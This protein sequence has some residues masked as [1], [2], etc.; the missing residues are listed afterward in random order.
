MSWNKFKLFQPKMFVTV[1]FFVFC[2]QLYNCLFVSLQCLWLISEAT[3]EIANQFFHLPTLAP[4]LGIKPPPPTL[5]TILL[6][7]TSLS[8][9]AAAATSCISPGPASYP[10]C[11]EEHDSA[12]FTLKQPWFYK[13][14]YLLCEFPIKIKLAPGTALSGTIRT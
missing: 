4:D 11:L 13:K 5:S 6:D 14:S 10:V 8:L 1:T 3:N 9:A 12:I 2:F 7:F